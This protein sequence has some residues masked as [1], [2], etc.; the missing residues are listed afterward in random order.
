MWLKLLRKFRIDASVAEH[1]QRKENAGTKYYEQ[2]VLKTP[3]LLR[4]LI[5]SLR[6]LLLE[7][8]RDYTLKR[9]ALLLCGFG[10]RPN[11][12]PFPSLQKLKCFS[13][14]SLLTLRPELLSV[15]SLFCLIPSTSCATQSFLELQFFSIRR[16]LLFLGK[17]G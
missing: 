7:R 3:Y 11:F 17:K 5:Y 4:C 16:S 8:P 1:C 9:K 13:H 15:R 12:P 14:V 6:A 2:A 10:F